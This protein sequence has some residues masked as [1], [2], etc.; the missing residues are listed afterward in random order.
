MST[1]IRDQISRRPVGDADHVELSRLVIEAAW[2]YEAS[3]RALRVPG[4]DDRWSL[5][6]SMLPNRHRGAA[7]AGDGFRQCCEANQGGTLHG[8][9]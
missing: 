7:L 5:R 6:P 2:D 3:G 9:V 1:T 8:I 4:F